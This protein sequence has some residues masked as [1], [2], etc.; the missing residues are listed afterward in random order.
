MN[1]TIAIQRALKLINDGVLSVDTEGRIWRNAIEN[2][3]RFL[4]I[5]PR[6]AESIGGKEYLRLALWIDGELRNVGA[7]RVVWSHVR[8]PIPD[9]MQINH[10]DLNKRNNAIVNLEVVSG[11][12]NIRHS[13]ANGRRHPW[14]DATRWRGRKRLSPGDIE[15]AKAMRQNGTFIRVIAETFDISITHAHRITS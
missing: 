10:R 7:H 14:S 9:G 8:G 15:R 1:D 12:E 5:V 6:R 11:A 4:A 13:Y 3:G 2:R